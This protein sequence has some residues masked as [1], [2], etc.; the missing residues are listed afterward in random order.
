VNPWSFT[1]ARVKAQLHTKNGATR[2]EIGAAMGGTPGRMIRDGSG[3]VGARGPATGAAVRPETAVWPPSAVFAFPATVQTT[4]TNSTPENAAPVAWGPAE[5]TALRRG[6]AAGEDPWDLIVIGGGITGAGVARDAAMRGLRVLLLEAQD[7]AFGTS[8]RSSRLVHG[9]VRYLEQ[10]DVGLVFEALR[11]RSRLYAMASH[12]VRPSRFLFPTYRGDRLGPWKLR[13]GLTL[14]DTLDFHRGEGHEY[15]GPEQTVQ[16]EPMLATGGLLG[17]VQYEDAITDDAR[18]TLA[19]LQD[20][21]RHGAR[22]LT[23]AKVDAIEPMDGGEHTV[24]LNDGMRTTTRAVVVATGPW[25][26]GRLLG[27]PAEDLLSLSKGI[28]IV[29]RRRDVPIARPL[30]VQA[31]HQR[32]ILFVIPWG[33]RTYLGTT[34]SPYDGDPGCCGVTEADEHELLALVGRMLP[35]ASLHPSRIVST[36]SGV[37]PLVR[38]E[39]KGASDTVELSRRHRIV[40]TNETVFGIV[41]GKLT[42]HRSMAQEIV[43]TVIARLRRR[44]WP[45]GHQRLS[46]CR[47]HRVPLAPGPPLA[48]Q[49]LACPLIADLAPRHGPAARFLAE[50]ARA[51][52]A[53]EPR[54]VDD[55]PYRWCEV[56]QAI[57]H[58]GATHVGDILRRRLP[59]TLTD[60]ALGGRVARAVAQRL[61]DAWGGNGADI[62]RELERFVDETWTETRRT[63]KLM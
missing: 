43:D 54:L 40:E 38:R 23:Y 17:A 44:G 55:L 56:D 57:H 25:M 33:T 3:I 35:G 9:G 21:L 34:D 14:Y 37:R 16:A 12:L 39:R 20:A 13:L 51:D 29:M 26:C 19:T 47:T 59:L 4:R 49:E 62:E 53:L 27:R 42:T 32:R 10:G 8:S 48:R 7:V 28:H 30:V 15:F 41:G 50:R 22:V 52:P 31:P 60:P 36:W 45:A 63:P 61:V 58:E 24:T 18:L 5:L 46:P 6:L 11:E 1:N 2:R